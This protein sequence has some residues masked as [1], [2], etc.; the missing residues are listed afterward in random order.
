MN[1][2]QIDK[3]C[4][5]YETADMSLEAMKAELLGAYQSINIK[6]IP[7]S[8]LDSDA[9]FCKLW[10]AMQTHPVPQAPEKEDLRRWWDNY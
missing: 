8:T 1:D 10:E 5:Y 2:D 3:I 7:S 6:N 4:D 9:V